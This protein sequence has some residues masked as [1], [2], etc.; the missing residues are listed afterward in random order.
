MTAAT[1]PAVRLEGVTKRY[2]GPSGNVVAV[3]G[4]DLT[5]ETGEI[6][7]L[8][9]VNGA[10]K[11]TVIEMI[12]GL[13]RP[14]SGVIRTVGFDPFRHRD[15]IRRRVAVQPQRAAMFDQQ[16]PRELLGV[17]ASFYP[18]PQEVGAVLD[19]LGLRD[20]ADVR[21]R[22]LSGGQQQRLLVALALVSRPRLLVLDEPSAGLDPNARADLWDALRGAQRS[23]ITI[24]MSTHAMDEAHALSDRIGILDRGRLAACDSPGRLLARYAA[25]RSV[26]FCVEPGLDLSWLDLLPGEVT[27]DCRPEGVQVTVHTG[28]SD[29]VLQRLG[30][31]RGVR[32]ISVQDDGIDGV[33]RR[34]TG[35]TGP[36]AG[37]ATDPEHAAATAGAYRRGRL[38]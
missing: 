25:A 1:G 17:W 14:T 8:L 5:V 13:R 16:T 12:V 38:P 37:E 15:E 24:V 2:T 18:R 11:T 32:R 22:T 4:L 9:G 35:R 30:G 10:G 29:T 33:F 27:T 20:S 3:D 31:H 26:L 36:P 7:T 28:D 6:V 34:V 19:Q 21:V 23:G